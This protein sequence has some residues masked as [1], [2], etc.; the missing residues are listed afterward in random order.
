[1]PCSALGHQPVRSSLRRAARVPHSSRT[2]RRT[3]VCAGGPSDVQATQ[4]CLQNSRLSVAGHLLSDRRRFRWLS[5][6]SSTPSPS[7]LS[8]RSP[9]KR[10]FAVALVLSMATA[11]PATGQTRDVGQIPLEELMELGVQRVFG[12][13]RPPA[14]RHR[15]PFVG[16]PSSRRTRSRATATGRWP[17]SCEACAASTSPTIATTATSA[18]AASTGRATTARACCCSSTVIA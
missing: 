9:M 2:V 15:G 11:I 17:T 18:R 4:L 1:M 13:V 14:A 5:H 10:R 6:L 12:A 8:F 7:P 3:Q 16:R